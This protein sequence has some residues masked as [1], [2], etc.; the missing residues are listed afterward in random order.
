M[1]KHNEVGSRLL[2]RR[3]QTNWGLFANHEDVN[4]D[5]LEIEG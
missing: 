5:S 2:Q 1:S 3:D 4:Q